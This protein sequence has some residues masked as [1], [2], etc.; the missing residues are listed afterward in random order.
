MNQEFSAPVE[1][2]PP[3]FYMQMLRPKL[4]LGFGKSKL[5]HETESASNLNTI[6]V[7]LCE[8]IVYVRV[9]K[10]VCCC[11]F[12]RCCAICLLVRLFGS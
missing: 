4:R 5:M 9:E 3:I 8:C 10:A 6:V 1:K 11:H 7:Y 12:V 2:Y